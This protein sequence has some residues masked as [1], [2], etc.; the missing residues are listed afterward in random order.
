VNEQSLSLKFCELEDGD[1][2][3][4]YKNTQFDIRS[5]KKLRL[6]IH[7]ESSADPAITPLSNGE[8]KC[9]MRLGS[10]FNENYYEYEI[11]LNITAPGSTNP[12][13]IW[14][15]ANEMVV[16]LQQLISAKLARNNAM[17]SGT[18]SVTL[19]TPYAYYDGT[20]KI[21]VKGT[22]N[23]SNLRSIMIGVRNPKDPNGSGAKLCGEVWFN[24][25]RLTDFDEQGGFASTA[26]LSAKLADLGNM[27][28]SGNRSTAGWGSLEKKVSERDRE[29]KLSYDFSTSIELG[30][31]LPEKSGIKIPFFFGYSEQKVNPQY[32]PLDPDVKLEQTL[33]AT[34]NPEV[35]NNLRKTV[36][37]YTQRKSYNFTNVRKVKTGQ[38][39]KAHV[40]D[41]ENLNFSY[42]YTEQFQRNYNVRYYIAK[43]YAGSV[44]YNY[45]AN[46]KP[47]SPFEKSKSKT[48][49]S[50]WLKLIKDFNFNP[51]PT[52]L[53]FRASLER[54]YSET[55]LRNNNEFA[56]EIPLPTTYDKTYFMRRNYGLIW[57]LTKSLKLDFTAD[58]HA[59]I[60]EPP[61]KIDTQDKHDLIMTNLRKLG[62]VDQYNHTTRLSYTL[63][64]SKIPLV[65]WISSNASYTGNYNW[66]ASPLY[67]DPLSDEIRVNDPTRGNTIQNSQTVQVGANLTLTSLYNKNKWLKK[68]STNAPQP[69][70]PPRPP[71]RS[72][73]DSLNKAKND[74]L[75]NKS[76]PIEPVAKVLAKALMMVK[77]ASVNYTETNGTLIPGWVPHPEFVGMDFSANGAPAPG[78]GF[79][80]GDQTDIRPA[81]VR[82]GW[83]IRPGDS[84]TAAIFNSY[85]T[86]TR[87]KNLSLRAT[88]EP[89]RSFKIE[90]TGTRNETFSH[91]EYYKYNPITDQFQSYS[92]TES[93]NFSISYLTWNTHFVTDAN[94]YSNKNFE[95]F[96]K[97]REQYSRILDEKNPNAPRT[98][99]QDSS[100]YGLT[101]K[102]VLTYS[103]LSAY[104][105]TAP[106]TK[107]TVLFPK[108]P[109]PNWRITYDG[110]SRV[111]ALASI[112]QSISLSH[113]YR[114]VYSVNSFT[115]NLL[116]TE[117]QKHNPTN[118]D[119]IGNFIPR[120][121]LQQITISEQLSPLI[122]IDMTFKNSLQARFEIKR[123]RTLSLAYSNSQV[124]EVRGI[125]YTIGLGYKFKRVQLPFKV[126]GNKKLSNDLTVKADVNLRDNTTILRKVVEHT[127]QPSQG[128]KTLGIKL[129]ADYPVTDRFNIRFF[130]DY[131]ATDPFVSTSYPTSNTNAGL[132]IRFTLAQ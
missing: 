1:A 14:P 42:A 74:T 93:G 19:Q 3:A 108:I 49:S 60:D 47:I 55:T 18:S 30:K 96:L 36:T 4:A 5:Y 58:V 51:V 17:Q 62:R 57:D 28:L 110:L 67:R 9:F 64:L 66:V 73:A 23:L 6:F 86:T 103:F 130:Y 12:S 105:G 78:W 68:I 115:Q 52:G 111:K 31:F 2:R 117:D 113:G 69:P 80:F 99:Y 121:D 71:A 77:T 100:G 54:N 128:S 124:T 127:N 101:Q 15:E 97:N 26:R 75:K 83:F 116:Y 44:G 61:G 88:V 16:D 79:V 41:V 50:R 125:E 46:V 102:E 131:N 132:A 81:A 13:D 21:T 32:N 91:S 29:D 104:R 11:P 84:A 119:T 107:N 59:M 39:S 82:N 40:Y 92:P 85:Y 45:N 25:L 95:Q 33:D 27:T 24:E 8:L 98:P 63:P 114:S 7:A 37:D 10:D 48:L 122:G 65:D 89:I 53:S 126:G 35:E 72:P 112:F 70:K 90:L 43:T 22:P 38:N 20:H 120:L 106:S 76:N 123:D 34:A 118:T 56:A 109:M 87:L 129:S 94:D